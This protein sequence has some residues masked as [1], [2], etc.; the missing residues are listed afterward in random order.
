MRISAKAEYACLA[1]VELA[2]RFTRKLPTSIK[3]IAESYGMSSAFLMQIFLQLKG[4]GLVMSVRGSSGG[5]QLARPP[6]DISL[7]EIVEAIDGP[8]KGSSALT[9]LS[10]SPVIDGLKGVWKTVDRAERKILQDLSL[11]DV[12]KQTHQAGIV[13]YQI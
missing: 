11:A 4:A 8:P 9:S 13:Y 2:K 7:A 10:S 6:E 5:Y 1:M 3:V 12:H